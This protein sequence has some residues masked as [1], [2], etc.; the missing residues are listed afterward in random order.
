[1]NN[2]SYSCAQ[3]GLQFGLTRQRISGT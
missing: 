3:I 2:S 1:L